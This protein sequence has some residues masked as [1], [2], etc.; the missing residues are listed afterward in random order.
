MFALFFNKDMPDID[1]SNLPPSTSRRWFLKSVGAIGAIGGALGGLVYWRRGMSDGKLTASG[2]DV[3]HG[4]TVAVV[5]P[6]LPKL[7]AEREAVLSDHLVH[8]EEFINGMPPAIQVEI[9]ALLGLLGNAPTRWA[10]TGLSGAWK[11]ASDEDVYQSLEYMRHNA[12]P[13]TRLAYQ[14]LR[15]IICLTFFSNSKNWQR[16]SYPG[17]IPL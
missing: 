12:L 11:D 3:F 5:G 13:T 9:N 2:R 10:L 17:P 6:V 1:N 14:T 7:S 15:G 16:A 4:L 8:V